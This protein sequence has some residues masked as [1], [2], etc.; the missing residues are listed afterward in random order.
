LRTL[1]FTQIRV[2]NHGDCA[3]IE[4]H[5]TEIER[6]WTMRSQIT[7]LCKDAGFIF[8][9]IDTQGYRTGAMNEALPKK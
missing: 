3:R 4:L 6:G 7:A 2:R 8:V 1:G 9:A 5:P